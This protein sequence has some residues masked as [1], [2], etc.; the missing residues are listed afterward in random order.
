M[1]N[2]GRARE[3][4]AEIGSAAESGNQEEDFYTIQWT[5]LSL[6]FCLNRKKFFKEDFHRHIGVNF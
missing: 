6:K 3:T 2:P 5:I 1:K 4:R